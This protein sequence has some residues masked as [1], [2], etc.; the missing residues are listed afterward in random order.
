M[1]FY[2]TVDHTSHL[3]S[4]LV[5]TAC[6]TP[7]KDHGLNIDY[8]SLERILYAQTVCQNG[9]I[10]FGST[11]EGLSLS[12]EEKK[13]ILDF[14]LRLD[15]NI[16]VL[17]SLPTYS[18][19]AAIECIKHCQDYEIQGYL[20]SMPLYTCPGKEGQVQWLQAV[21]TIA[22]KPVILYNIPRRTGVSLSVEALEILKDHPFLVGLKDSS[23]CLKSAFQYTKAAPRINLLCGD[24]HL[25]PAYSTLGAKGLVSVLSNLW[26]NF[27]KYYVQESL[28]GRWRKL[29]FWSAQNALCKATNPIPVKALMR[30]LNLIAS[31]M[32]R[33]PLCKNDIPDL[34]PLRALHQ[35]A[36]EEMEACGISES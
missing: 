20:V 17:C 33:L 23:G 5:W 7:F 28:A 4:P 36:L 8:G 2:E 6:I 30:L 12:V 21:L 29:F 26:P 34:Q 1:N 25:M 24:D 13:S 14:V 10:L 32:V 35:A 16:P 18:L 9:I 31:D 19:E 22:Q 15:L 3:N 27:V 11:G